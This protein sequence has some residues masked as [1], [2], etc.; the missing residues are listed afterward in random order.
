[1]DNATHTAIGLFLSRAG[2]NRLSPYATPIVIVA[3]NLPDLDI[4][5][6]AGGAVNYLHYHRHLTHSLIA[7]PVVALAA[8][9]IV[10]AIVRKPV[11][12][13]GAFIAALIGVAS[14]LALDW[15]NVY[16]VRMLLPFS[17]EWLRLDI[18]SVIDPWIWV[19]CGLGVAGPFLARLVGGEIGS[20]GKKAR[21][22]GRGF[23]WFAL[24]FVL[25]YDILRGNLHARAVATLKSRMYE[26][27]P[28]TRALATPYALN[29][30]RWRGVVET[31]GAWFVQELNFAAIS[32]EPDRP[33]VFH[34]PEPELAIEAARRS[35][36]IA[37]FLAFSQAPLWRVT[38][39]PA[40]ENGRLVEVIDMRFGTPLATGFMAKA[41]VN[42]RGEVVDSEFHYVTPRPR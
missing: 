27:V 35:P 36:A 5:T 18:T 15:T 13:L 38:P 31:P 11:Q 12:W 26:D 10:C 8:I 17:G 40:I 28:P 3:S 39:W 21:H 20:G 16:G 33:Q 37:E 25:S 32:P 24:L 9:A 14:H 2:L 22:H 42:G 6:A 41:V 4:V 29:P 7:M 23:A 30:F 19:V 34:K 1:M